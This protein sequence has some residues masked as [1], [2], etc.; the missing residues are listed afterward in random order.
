MSRHQFR[1]LI[2]LNQF[3]AFGTYFV[4]DLTDNYLPPELQSYLG[5][6]ESVLGGS[7]TKV[8]NFSYSAALPYWIGVFLLFLGIF[9]ALGLWFGRKW[10][11]FLFLAIFTT[12]FL[13]IPFTEVYI[14]NRWSVLIANLWTLTDS[15]ILTLAYF[16]HLRRMFEKTDRI[17]KLIDEATA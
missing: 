9:A 6:S 10:G 5:I 11:R 1:I 8:E 2:V 12:T 15:I 14:S 16:S 4:T 13:L 3:L 7:G 17:D